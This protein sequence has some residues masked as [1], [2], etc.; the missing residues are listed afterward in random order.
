M[1]AYQRIVQAYQGIA[2]RTAYVITGDAG[3]AEEAAQDAFVKA[4]RA[5]PR[6][7]GEADLGTWLYRITYNA[8]LDHLRRR[9]PD[10]VPLEHAEG[11]VHGTADPAHGVVERDA[12]ARALRALPP[13]QR[14]VLLMVDAE[15]YDYAA[16]GRALGI[17][18]GT[19]ASRLSHARAAVRRQLETEEGVSHERS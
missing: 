10:G 18:A 12:L 5:L 13:Q 6:F 3:D 14:A 16:A 17:A 15:G 4:F 1:G 9:R 7:R 11:I 19:V 2:F 8:C